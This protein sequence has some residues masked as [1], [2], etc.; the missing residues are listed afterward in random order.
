L[1]VKG[2]VYQVFRAFSQAKNVR[3]GYM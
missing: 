1:Q 3:A 2:K